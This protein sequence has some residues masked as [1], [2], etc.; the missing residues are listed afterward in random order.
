MAI[1]FNLKDVMHRIIV[2]FYR[3]FLPNAKKKYILRTVYQP[4]LDI[5]GIASKA[6][7]YNITTPPKVIEEGLTDGLKLITCLVAYGFKI[8]TPIF[9]LKVAIPGEYDGVE[10]HFPPPPPT[11]LRR[12]DASL[13]R[14]NCGNTSP[15]ISKFNS[16]VL[17]KPTA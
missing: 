1:D 4:E 11:A 16:T 5:H 10:T 3:A 8:K 13:S 17:R 9:N 14:T 15:N 2:K 6:E 7:V 12:R